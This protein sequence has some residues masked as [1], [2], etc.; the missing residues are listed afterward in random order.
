[1]DI[2][3]AIASINALIIAFLI[4]NKKDKSLSDKILIAWIMAFAIHFSTPFFIERKLFFHEIYWG[5][6]LGI[7]ITSHTPF[8]FIYTNSLTDKKFKLNLKNLWHFG[9]ILFYILSFMPLLLLGT[10][11]HIE[12]I[13]EKQDLTYQVFLP[14]I[15]L[16]FCQVYFLIRTT[17]VL[18]K[19]QYNIK[20]E[21]SYEKE[22]DLSWIKRIVFGFATIIVLSF[23]A[24]AMVSA[25]IISLYTMDYSII[26]ANI[27]LFF[28]IAYSGYH[29]QDIFK[30]EKTAVHE[31]EKEKNKLVSKK[32]TSLLSDEKL[33]TKNNHNPIIEDLLKLM[34]KEKLYLNCE[35]TLG[36]LANQINIHSQQLS[37]LINENLH[38]N[39]FEF[40]NDFRILEFKRLAAN[41]K[42]KHISILGLAMDAGFNSKA[43]FN[44]IFKNSTG[45]TPSEYRNSFHF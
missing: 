41:P 37:K 13:Y 7:V 44:R 4:A 22:I 43:S 14:M 9:F 36:E 15:T 21:F 35:L 11:K 2:V 1:M 10:E 40:V 20:H 42:H 24:Y 8:L 34:E 27:I 28:Y 3:S 19:H 16:L 39:F 6:I 23:I 17:I 32:E 33:V 31:S 29:Q 30:H 12:L 38:K 25:N 45:L 5:F 18:V 26:V